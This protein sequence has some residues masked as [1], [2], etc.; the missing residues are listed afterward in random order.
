M[1]TMQ[2]IKSKQ[3]DEDDAHDHER[4]VVEERQKSNN[5][6]ITIALRRASDRETSVGAAQSFIFPIVINISC[7]FDWV[8][9]RTLLAAR[10]ENLLLMPCNVNIQY[11]SA[12]MVGEQKHF[13]ENK[14]DPVCKY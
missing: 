9:P 12:W 8:T 2:K 7:P 5:L 13:L 3:L 11:R 6:S 10:F 14:A 4:E 1:I